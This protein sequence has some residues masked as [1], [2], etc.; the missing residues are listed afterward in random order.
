MKGLKKTQ[1]ATDTI[2]TNCD[3]VVM[4]QQATATEAAPSLC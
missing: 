4:I 1:K 3:S 2:I